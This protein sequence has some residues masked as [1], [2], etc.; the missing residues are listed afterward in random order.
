MEAIKRQYRSRSLT[1]HSLTVENASFRL[2][3][4]RNQLINHELAPPQAQNATKVY[5]I[6]A[7]LTENQIR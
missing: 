4:K 1:T 5:P 2:R 6:F 7:F 3:S